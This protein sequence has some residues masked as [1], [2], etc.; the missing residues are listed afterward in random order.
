MRTGPRS[1]WTVSYGARWSWWRRPTTRRQARR[2]WRRV[3]NAA[4]DSFEVTVARVD[5]VSGDVSG[6]N[7][8]Y[9][10]VE[11]GVYANM[12]AVRFESTSRTTPAS[13]IG[14]SRTYQNAY[15]APVVVGQVMTA[16]DPAYL[17]LL[18]TGQRF[19]ARPVASWCRCLSAS[20]WAR[21][22]IQLD[23]PETIGVHRDRGGKGHYWW[24]GVPCGSRGRLGG[25]HGRGS[26][27]I[28]TKPHALE[29]HFNE[30]FDP[31]SIG[32]QDLT[33]GSG[34]VAAQKS[35]PEMPLS[36]TR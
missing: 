33:L 19:R 24:T 18:G 26:R 13:W 35:S 5:G 16:N 2:W 17:G 1:H 7:V 27:E 10:V 21:T 15:A 32:T 14:E 11:A 29:V 28:Q 4:D 30:P 3:R 22:R 31:L 8:H 6:V 9:V 20:T 36:S 23:C 34:A 12:E 25:R